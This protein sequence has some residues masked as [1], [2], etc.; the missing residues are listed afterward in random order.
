MLV[1]NGKIDE[2]KKPQTPVT[3]STQTIESIPVINQLINNSKVS[4][5]NPSPDGFLSNNSE[6]KN[7]ALNNIIQVYYNDLL[8]KNYIMFLEKLKSEYKFIPNV[9]YD[10]GASTLHWTRHAERIWPKSEII[11]FDAFQPAT[12]LYKKYNYYCG[13]LSDKD[14]KQVKFYQNDILFA[15]NSYYKEINKNVYP[16]DQYILKTTRTLDSIVNERNFPY[17]DLIKID[18]Q[19][20]ELDIIKGAQ[21]ILAYAKYL[22]VELQHITYNEGAPLVNE[23]KK[24]LE[25]IGWEC[26][27]EKFSDN[28]P[29]ADYCFRNT[30]F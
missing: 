14:N 25:S 7:M 24:Y 5:I 15:G 28:G 8:N 21:N 3:E 12:I 20:A 11:L 30:L 18:V 26:I 13:V 29:D 16:E 10:I 4:N 6:Y 19:G 9:C 27:A 22:L 23:T 2:F 17:P 1:V